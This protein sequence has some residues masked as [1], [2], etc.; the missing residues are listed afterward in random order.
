[1]FRTQ[2]DTLAVKPY[3]KAIDKNSYL[4]YKSFHPKPL[5]NS[6]PY[7]QFTRIRRNSSFTGD[8]VSQSRA[9][10]EDFLNRGYP[11]QLIYDAAARAHGV[12]WSDLFKYKQKDGVRFKGITATL[13]FTPLASKIKYIIKQ[14]WHLVKD[15]PGCTSPP[16]WGLRR[17]KTLKDILV[18]SDIREHHQRIPVTVG[19]RCCAQ[20][21]E[22]REITLPAKGFKKPLNFFSSCSPRMCVYLVVCKCEMRYVGSTRRR[23]KVRIMEHKSRIRNTVLDAPMVQHF[24]DAGHSPEDFKFAVLEMVTSTPDKGG[25]IHKKLVQRESFWIFKLKTMY[26]YG[27]N[28]HMDLTVFF[29]STNC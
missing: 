1:M 28:S 15:L 3:K 7:G 8:Y 4:H 24:L 17:T 16:R 25:D 6:I 20:A 21:W 19:H 11:A 27:L 12:E 26:P 29:K 9:M 14:H 10:K 2:R 22:T 5:H 13:D 23:L 18:R